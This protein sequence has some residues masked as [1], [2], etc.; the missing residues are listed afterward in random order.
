M[1]KKILAIVVGF[2]VL[3]GICICV[4]LFQRKNRDNE[5][6]NTTGYLDLEIDKNQIA[7]NENA[8]IDE[9][10]EDT[11]I[12]GNNEIYELQTEFDGRRVLVV[13]ANIK[14][15][16]AFAG[17]IKNDLPQMNELD[18]ILEENF[19]KNNGV[20]V[21]AGSRDKL[22]KLINNS[23]KL[24]SKYSINDDG[25]IIITE[26]NNQTD[27]DKKFESTINNNQSSNILSVSSVCYTIDDV[28][29]KIIDNDF[30]FM[31]KYQTYD[32]F[33]DENKKIIFITENKEEQL[34]IDE[35]I[36]SV[37]NLL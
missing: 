31:D 21:N 4:L 25:Y 18:T 19:P 35:I 37:I 16:V 15:K 14:Y 9:I 32:Y 13:K 29:G 1:N 17:M 34:P 30:E 20:W 11:G 2:I 10:K 28:T 12:S 26:K 3:I 6:Q 5:M 7:Y 23:T 36:E 8:T 22:L 27:L 33:E 24:N